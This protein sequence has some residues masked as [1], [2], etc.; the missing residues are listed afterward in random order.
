MRRFFTLA[1]CS[2]TLLIQAQIA[3]DLEIF[4]DDGMLFTL[5]VNGQLITEEPTSRI[6]LENTNHDYLSVRM[7]VNG[8]SDVKLERTI[9]IIFPSSYNQKDP[10]TAVYKIKKKKNRYK[11]HLISRS[12]KKIQVDQ[13]VRVINEQIVLDG[14]RRRNRR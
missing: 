4:A 13:Q 3:H 11:L 9:P 1:F 8:E 5:E 14:N 7:K 6:F 12:Y 2:L 10:V